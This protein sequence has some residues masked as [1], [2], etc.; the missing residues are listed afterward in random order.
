MLE[1]RQDY[2]VYCS[3]NTIYFKFF[4]NFIILVNNRL[5]SLLFYHYD[6]IE[7]EVAMEEIDEFYLHSDKNDVNINSIKFYVTIL[8]FFYIRIHFMN[9]YAHA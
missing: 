2:R 5:Y 9:A 7:P 4:R 6:T 8:H 1:E 3:M